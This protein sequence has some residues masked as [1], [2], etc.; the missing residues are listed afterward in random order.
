MPLPFIPG[1]EPRSERLL[2]RFLPPLGEGVAAHYIEQHTAP[3]DLLFDPFGQAPEVALE[4]LSLGR[5]LIVANFN[6]ISRLALSLAARPPTEAELRSA[7]TQLADVRKDVER[8]ETYLRGLYQT[9]CAMCGASVS[10]DAFEWDTDRD[11]HAPSAKIY[12]CPQ[13]G[14]S[15]QHQP[16]DD[17][18]RAHAHHF[19]AKGPDY[20]ILLERVTA[21]DDA[22]RAYAEEALTIYPPRALTA[23]ATTLLKLDVL[24]PDPALRRVL[25]GLLIAAFEMTTTLGP[26]RPKALTSARRFTEHNFWL[27]LEKAISVIGGAAQPDRSGS[28]AEVLNRQA[29]IYAHAGPARDMVPH[30]PPEACALI[31]SAFPRPSP[32]YWALSAVWAAWLWGRDAAREAATA[33][34]QVLR[35]RRYDWAWHAEALE[36]TLTAVAP[37]LKLDGKLIALLTEA[38]PGFTAATFTAA[39]RAGYALLGAARQ[40][41]MAEAQAVWARA[42]QPPPPFAEAHLRATAPTAALEVLRA[43]GEPARWSTVHFGIWSALGAERLL[44]TVPAEPL[45]KVNRW[46]EAL[47]RDADHFQRLEAEAEDDVT[48]GW[49]FSAPGAVIPNTALS[50]RVEA[51]V[52]RR[53]AEGA[54]EETELLRAV[55][56]AFPG[57]QTPGRGLVLACLNSYAQPNDLG[58]WQLRPED[59][60][61]AR[62]QELN[63]IQ[64]ELRA[65]AARY[66]FS[67]AGANP[68]EWR[69]ETGQTEYV[70]AV[71][72]SAVLSTHLL[73]PLLPARRRFVVLPGGRAGLAGF[74]LRRDARLRAALQAG[75][76]QLLKF[77]QL[78]RIAG[79]AHLTPAALE[80]ALLADPVAEVMDET[81]QL[82]L[83]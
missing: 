35:R 65:L 16:A 51:E 6:P 77:R 64:A 55:C 74:K 29:A 19:R 63:A 40:T 22:D 5:R 45:G 80:S 10:A 21:R 53:L 1:Y 12:F 48:T 49:W 82:M 38:E 75:Q 3:G 2:A 52:L 37:T 57:I 56:A 67:V 50:D 15:A 24:N 8:L 72:T 58:L 23:I 79:E 44:A 71:I 68:Q 7:L 13:C 60:S 27:A 62:A 47:A 17:A 66:G 33:L 70:F 34:R 11:P 76:W 36:H 59:G 26:E 69:T 25:S 83:M 41:D 78:R 81:R 61:S 46:L 18:D 31:I 43:R 20:Y 39:D 32:A 30:L 28:L 9:T 54:V 73:A 42:A 14:G 4:A